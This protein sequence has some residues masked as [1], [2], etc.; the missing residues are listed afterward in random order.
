[1]HEHLPRTYLWRFRF[2]R[3]VC[4][5]VHRPSSPIARQTMAFSVRSLGKT[6]TS[7]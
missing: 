1:M 2:F 5:S 3:R 4:E 7:L 6:R